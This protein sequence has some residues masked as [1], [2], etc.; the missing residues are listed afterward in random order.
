MK[1]AVLSSGLLLGATLLA[2][3]TATAPSKVRVDMAETGLPNCQSF[4]WLPTQQQPASLTEQRVKSEVMSQLKQ[5]GYTQAAEKGDC[6]VTYALD[7]Y[8]RPANKPGV[9][10]GVGG[11]SGGVGGGIGVTLPIGK[12][13]EQA[14]TF[15]IDIVDTAK[16]AQVWSGSL[17]AS[18]LKPE[19]NEDETREIVARILEKYPDREPK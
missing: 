12:R 4:E 14:G 15:T 3:C 18:F 19:P 1:T 2:G 13:A 10:V 9:G 16:N 17:D 8:E 11:G 6:R 5:K 7:I